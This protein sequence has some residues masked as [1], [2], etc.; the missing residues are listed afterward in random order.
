MNKIK[1]ISIKYIILLCMMISF[2]YKSFGVI[3]ITAN[4]AIWDCSEYIIEDV[5]I[6]TNAQLTIRATY[7]FSANR[8]I[9][10]KKGGVLI[11][12]ANGILTNAHPNELWGGDNRLWR[13]KLSTN[14]T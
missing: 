11:L 6:E 1:N 3:T 7:N 13:F 5:V 10:V 2:S 12:E 4:D 9:Y 14:N 8:H